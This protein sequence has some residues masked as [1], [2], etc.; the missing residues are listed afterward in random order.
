MITKEDWVDWKKNPVT[1]V[2]LKRVQEKREILKEGLAE[3]AAEQNELQRTIGRCM[4]LADIL[5]E[6]LYN[7]LEEGEELDD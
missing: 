3:G 4:S 1:L 7:F 5:N 6:A 2:F